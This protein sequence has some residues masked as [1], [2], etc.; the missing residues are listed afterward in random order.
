MFRLI[1]LFAVGAASLSALAAPTTAVIT[2]SLD[3]VK[4][5]SQLIVPE[6]ATGAQRALVMVPNWMGIDQNN[7][8]QAQLIA[9]RGYVVLLADVYGKT[10]RP[11][12]GEEAGKAAGALKAGDRAAL[13]ARMAAALELLNSESKKRG[14]AL[15]G[16][17]AIGFCFG[18]TSVLEL[19]RAGSSVNGVVSFHGGLDT[20]QPAQKGTLNARVL[21]LHG[22]DDPYVPRPQVQAFED[23]MRAAN[24]D[25]QLVS[26]GGAVH[27]FT[28]VEAKAKGQAEYNAA[29]ARRAYAAMDDFFAEVIP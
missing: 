21:A 5:E 15:K 2:H 14:L 8:N 24:A 26:Y 12:N 25:W 3:G 1:S 29:V 20:A 19:A 9:N 18:G 11:K 13:R 27:S 23:E 7:I 10:V 6:G 17:G 4:F 28:D 22:A 16:V